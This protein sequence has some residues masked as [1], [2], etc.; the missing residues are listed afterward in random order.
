MRKTSLRFPI[1]RL[2]GLAALLSGC[3]SYGL[4]QNQADA[5]LDNNSV[6]VVVRLV[7]A[8][9]MVTQPKPGTAGM[10]ETK[11]HHDERLS[12]QYRLRDTGNQNSI[13]I[14]DIKDNVHAVR[15]SGGL[16][17]PFTLQYQQPII[18]TSTY[19]SAKVSPKIAFM[20][21]K[22]GTVYYLGQVHLDGKGAIR[23]TTDP[24]RDS[25]ELYQKHSYL[26]NQALVP[27]KVRM[28][29]SGATDY[30]IQRAFG[31]R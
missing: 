29:D 7:T 12:S 25:S 5:K 8:D 11:K 24:A 6:I 22:G 27:V 15:I 28:F 21:P 20:L 19:W 4:V 3:V 9:S 1:L 23:V 14:L 10:L 30:Q 13:G 18:S 17:K 16:D 31:T 26:K 2:L